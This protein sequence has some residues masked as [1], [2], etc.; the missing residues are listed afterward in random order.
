M[1]W[2]LTIAGALLVLVVLHD[3]FHTLWHPRGFGS[4]GRAVFAAV[5]W[6]AWRTR[7][8]LT[9]PI[10]LLAVALLW[11]VL[12]VAGWTLIYLPH[13]PAGFH[14]SSPLTPAASHDLITATYL[15]MVTVATLG[16]GDIVPAYPA[17]RLLAPLQALIGFAV[18]TAVISWVLQV[19]PALIRRR[20]LARQLSIMATTDTVTFLGEGQASVVTQLLQGLVDQ[21]STVRVDLLQ[22]GASYYFRE[23]DPALSLA[24]NLPY[25]LDLVAAGK[26]VPSADVRHF[27]AMLD[28]AVS[29]LAGALE[30]YVGPGDTV[31]A[32]LE[33]F[34][35]DHRQRA[36]HA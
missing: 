20:S 26:R 11:T 21:L 10:G 32:V 1:T 29:D 34:A 8:E 23:E 15:S 2:V 5:W 6:L 35:G 13:M 28:E 14:F 27:A 4:M 25:T 18:L 9:G 30:E 33:A 36:L 16:Y 3:M 17:L 19:Y 22:Y 24:A 31:P 12:T 7:T